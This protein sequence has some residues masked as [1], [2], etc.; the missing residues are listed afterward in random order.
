MPAYSSLIDEYRKFLETNPEDN[1]T[2]ETRKIYLRNASKLLEALITFHS[3]ET[4]INIVRL[5]GLSSPESYGVVISHLRDI[6]NR[7]KRG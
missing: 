3:K 6:V 1:W 2:K 5:R 4:L 7:R